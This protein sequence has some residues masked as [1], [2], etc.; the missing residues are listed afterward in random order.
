[1]PGAQAEARPE[2]S[3]RLQ[4]TGL[5]AIDPFYRLSV[6]QKELLWQWRYYLRK[7]KPHGLA[8]IIGAVTWT[9]PRQ[10]AEV[11]KLLESWPLINPRYALALLVPQFA[12]VRVRG[13]AIKC[14]NQLT[15]HQLGGYMLQ[16][17]SALKYE[18]SLWK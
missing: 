5:L 9:N 17:T 4:L 14:L 7:E 8:R 15:D 18:N 6:E 10:V 11:H 2:E 3:A 13:F 12:D 16:L 1:M